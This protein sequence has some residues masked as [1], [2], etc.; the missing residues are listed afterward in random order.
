M[1]VIKRGK[2]AIWKTVIKST[3]AERETKNNTITHITP[4]KP[5]PATIRHMRKEGM[6]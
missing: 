2:G 3:E 6:I 4:E 5:T 1:N